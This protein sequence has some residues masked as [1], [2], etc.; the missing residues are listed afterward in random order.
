MTCKHVFKG[1][2]NGVVCVKCGKRL[3][4]DEYVKSLQPKEKG[5]KEKSKKE[6]TNL[7]SEGN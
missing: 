1:M 2:A 3:S 4:H 7:S 6:V 5:V